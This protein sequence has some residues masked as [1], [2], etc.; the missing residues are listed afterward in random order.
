MKK[1]S[2]R[3]TKRRKSMSQR[4]SNLLEKKRKRRPK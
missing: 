3:K 1:G 4:F 2:K